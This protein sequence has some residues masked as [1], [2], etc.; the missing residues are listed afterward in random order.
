[1]LYK[2]Y[3]LYPAS[4]ETGFYQ[5]KSHFMKS[6]PIATFLG[7]IP[8]N[9]FNTQLGTTMF[10]TLVTEIQWFTDSGETPKL[11]SLAARLV[12]EIE[13]THSAL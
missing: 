1:M 2:Y 12:R 9:T 11:V 7:E 4:K 13:I 3:H 8:A 5:P 6:S 10:S